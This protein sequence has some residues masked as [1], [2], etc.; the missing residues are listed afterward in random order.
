MAMRFY[1]ALTPPISPTIDSGWVGSGTA[2]Q[3]TM[4]VQSKT[5]F[6]P[7]G[8]GGNSSVTGNICDY[9]AISTPLRAQTISGYVKGIALAN[10]NLDT[11][12]ACAQLIIRLLSN[13]G[14]VVRGT[15]LAPDNSALSNE[16][17]TTSQNRKFPRNWS[18][19]GVALSPVAAQAGDRLVIEF[20]YRRSGDS[21]IT[22]SIL[23]Y[24]GAN[25]GSSDA[26]ENETDTTTTNPWVE[27]SQDLLF[28]PVIHDLDTKSGTVTS[29]S[30]NWTLTYPTNLASGDLVLAFIAQDGGGASQTWPA[31]FV[32]N[33]P[34]SPNGACSLYQAKKISDGT[35]TGNFTVTVDGSEQ[36]AWRIF[37]VTGW[38]GTL[39]T[40]FGNIASSGSVVQSDTIVGSPSLNPDPLFLNPANWITEDT[41]WFAACAVDT[42]RTISVYPLADHNTADVSGGAGGA[43]LGLCATTSAVDA[44]DPG[45][46]TISSSDDWEA[47]V[48]AVRPAAAAVVTA[49]AGTII[50]QAVKRASFY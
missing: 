5:N 40:S 47:A 7:T 11:A 23:V 20:G 43:T 4:L 9:Q 33:S 2:F 18:G 6:G 35:E 14:T 1:S 25:S 42:S 12:D 41:L 49:R 29:N 30:A 50:S 13:D 26:A 45:T 36:G 3:R 39:G 37:R 10:E 22:R 24:S 19:S 17:N 48:V 15:L 46:F 21:G 27:F 44:L 16:F 38:E 32:P 8:F 34:N 31:G 28:F